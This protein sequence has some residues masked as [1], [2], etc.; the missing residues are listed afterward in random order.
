MNLLND[1]MS[2]LCYSLSA[3]YS[4]FLNNRFHDFLGAGSGSQKRVSWIGGS[5]KLSKVVRCLRMNF[6]SCLI[7][8]TKI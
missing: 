1:F 8:F 3:S 6:Q 5:Q 7:G 4:K 2:T